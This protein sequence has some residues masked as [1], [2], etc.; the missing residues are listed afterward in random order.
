M[1]VLPDLVTLIIIHG[2][3]KQSSLLKS[4]K[5]HIKEPFYFS[6]SNVLKTIHLQLAVGTL[7]VWTYSLGLFLLGHSYFLSL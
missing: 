3:M 5:S 4:S 6:Q 1:L 7:F 2:A